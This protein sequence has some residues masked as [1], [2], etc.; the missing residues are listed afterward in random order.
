MIWT[1]RLAITCAAL[2]AASSSQAQSPAR[3]VIAIM[4]FT[5]GSLVDHATYAPFSA[6]VVGMLMGELRNNSS[7]VLVERERLRQVLDEIKL[8][9]TG[10][11]DPA[12][13]AKAGKVLGARHM[14]FGSFIIDRKGNLRLDARSVNVET[15]EVEHVET[16]TDDADNLLRAVQKLGGQLNKGLKLPGDASPPKSGETA[17]KGQV[18]ADLK[19]AR[20]LQ[21]EDRKNS[22]KAAQ[23][24]REFLA[25]SPA[26][27]A[28]G[29]RKEAEAR[30]KVLTAGGS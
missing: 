29:L 14:I 20:A 21:E 17:R 16:V 4:D 12:T 25:E 15:S 18:L 2:L 27:Y 1:G 19:Y 30:I 6:G 24:Y 9:Q 10:E 28:P 7:I 22:A 5:N 26:D 23:F 3:P 13:A 8:G 11:V